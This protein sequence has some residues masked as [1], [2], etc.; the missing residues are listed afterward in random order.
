M[1]GSGLNKAVHG[2]SADLI[3]MSEAEQALTRWQRNACA[4]IKANRVM[5]GMTQAEFAEAMGSS[6]SRVA[7]MEGHAE[8]ST[9]FIMRAAAV[10]D[11]L[12]TLYANPDLDDL[13][14]P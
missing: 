5:R 2:S 9:D 3:G 11:L 8:V 7:K 12:P 13:Q 14:L 1:G 4:L 6:Q 10:L